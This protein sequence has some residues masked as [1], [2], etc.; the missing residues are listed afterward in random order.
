MDKGT[1]L[2]KINTGSRIVFDGPCKFC[3]VLKGKINTA[4]PGKRQEVGT[5]GVIDSGMYA[6][7]I[8]NS[9]LLFINLEKLRE[10]NPE[11]AAKIADAMKAGSE[12]S[13]KNKGDKLN[14]SKEEEN[15]KC[16]GPAAK[17]ERTA[18]SYSV[19]VQCPVCKSH[20]KAN[21]LFE[22]KLKQLNHDPK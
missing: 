12:T 15:K 19:D 10:L 21:K 6:Y 14:K 22:S 9:E 2:K 17:Q 16:G 20:F 13:G 8:E 11:L 1:L 4:A 3:L 7:A 5:G 18:Y